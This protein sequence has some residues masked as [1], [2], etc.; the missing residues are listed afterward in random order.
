MK[1]KNQEVIFK[2]NIL[3]GT[4]SF[5]KNKLFAAATVVVCKCKL[6]S[7]QASLSEAKILLL[8]VK[9]V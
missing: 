1:T 2:I 3:L 9:C 5:S 8:L 7:R 4:A 6:I